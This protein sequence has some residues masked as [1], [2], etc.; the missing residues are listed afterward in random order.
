MTTLKKELQFK[1]GVDEYIEVNTLLTSQLHFIGSI[2]EL[3]RELFP[4]NKLIIKVG[5]YEKGSFIVNLIFETGFVHSLFKKE[6]IEIAG[7][8][9]TSFAA[10]LDLII[11][12]KGKKAKSVEEKG[13]TVIINVNGNDNTINIDKDLFNIYKSNR[14]LTESISKN[15]ELLDN[16]ND[17]QNITIIDKEKTQEIIKI[18]KEQFNSLTVQNPYF[19][20]NK[21]EQT[22]YN[23]PLFIK[24][25]NL[26]PEK[27]RVYRGGF[28][29]RGRDIIAKISDPSFPK[30]I[31]EGLRIAQGDRLICDLKIYYKF[32]ER[33]MTYI[34]TNRFEIIKVHEV[35]ERPVTNQLSIENYKEDYEDDETDDYETV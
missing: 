10:I 30:K 13:N 12:L 6:N 4:D 14:E 11:K 8:I 3:Q 22:L 34:E 2:N 25:P 28:L 29:Y 33:F 24:K 5:P 32:D 16:D 27:G 19:D 35:I 15:F 18:E 21:D 20:T 1:Y 31:N 9:I 17:I 23:Q 26:F 7:L